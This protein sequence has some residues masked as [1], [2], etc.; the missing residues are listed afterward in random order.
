VLEAIDLIEEIS[1]RPI[2]FT[3]SDD[4]REGDHI[5][6]VSDV[7]RFQADYPDWRYEYDLRSMIEEIVE[8]A[9]AR[10]SA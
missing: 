10:F 6:W 9:T 3:L 1:G 5:W 7:R 2:D 8:A 4:A